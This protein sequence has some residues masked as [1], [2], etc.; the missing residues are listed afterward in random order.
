MFLLPQSKG[1]ADPLQN[2]KVASAWFG[3]LPALDVLARQ[4][5]VLHAFS[6]MRRSWTEIS[7]DRISAIA[8]I[9]AA[10]ESEHRRLIQWYLE[11]LSTSPR[12]AA[13]FRQAAIEV[14]QSFIDAYQTALDPACGRAGQLRWKPLI[15]LLFTRLIRCHGIDA[16]LRLFNREQWIPA[17][18]TE[19]H[20]LFLR[21]TELRVESVPVTLDKSDPFAASRSAEQEYV[22]VL[23]IAQLD[24]GNL[25]PAE[26]QW[27]SVQLRAWTD[28]IKLDA[29][30][31]PSGGFYVDLAGNKALC[32]APATITARK[33]GMST[34]PASRGNS[35]S[36]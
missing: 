3:K 6:V 36:R 17:R 13:R 16:K 4:Q 31:P 8:Y 21:A 29:A 34:R 25:S 20:Q 27:A 18:W 2:R 23:L 1:Y 19:L 32:A 26:L 12:L 11:N 14:N 10:F 33:W 35:T 7:R 9:D 15:P 5:Q 28:D 24:T 30:P 22:Y